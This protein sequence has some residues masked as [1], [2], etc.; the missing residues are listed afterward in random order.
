MSSEAIIQQS[1]LAIHEINITNYCL[2]AATVLFIY[3]YIITFDQELEV[4]WRRKTTWS[5]VLYLLNRYCVIPY[6]VTQVP[7]MQDTHCKSTYIV[8]QVGNGIECVLYFLWAAFS[9]LRVYAI[10]D[11]GRRLPILIV[12]LG[13]VPSIT[14]IY[15]ASQQVA[16]TLPQPIPCAVISK[17]PLAKS[18]KFAA[19]TRACVIASDALVLL[20]TWRT[21][22]AIKKAADDKDIKVS[23]ITL[24]LRDGTIYF[25]V[26][27]GLNVLDIL[28]WSL[29]VF[30]GMPVFITV[31]SPIL[32]CRFYLNLR[33]VHLSTHSITS[34]SQQSEMSDPKF[35]SRVVGNMGAPLNH[36][37]SFE[38]AFNTSD[39]NIDFVAS[40]SICMPSEYQDDG[41]SEIVERPRVAKEPLK[42]GLGFPGNA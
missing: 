31:F 30:D 6:L 2:T 21:T 25:G 42:D 18:N 41:F 40:D 35:A 32:I 22:Y 8:A 9:A 19:A 11:R 39:S 10:N 28:L 4:V 26:L 5:S 1:I 27:F 33:Q 34:E 20:I 37:S 24:L 14:N 16:I 7:F 29:D 15:N 13:S 23:T 38:R 36:G 3:D 17:L 12:L